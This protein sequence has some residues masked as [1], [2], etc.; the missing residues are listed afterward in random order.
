MPDVA[1]KYI[2]LICIQYMYYIYVYIFD[3]ICIDKLKISLGQ[4]KTKNIAPE[5]CQFHNW[6]SCRYAT[7]HAVF[8][9]FSKRK[10]K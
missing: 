6:D 5:L 9:L 7:V 2:A 3:Y 4:Q 8:M 1:P 10:E